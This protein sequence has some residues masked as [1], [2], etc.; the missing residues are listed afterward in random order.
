LVAK[1]DGHSVRVLGCWMD[2][3]G[4][5]ERFLGAGVTP[6]IGPAA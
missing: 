1:P 2:P 5:D 6:V 4:V 3:P